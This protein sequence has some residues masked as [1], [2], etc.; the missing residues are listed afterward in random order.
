M[1]EETRRRRR[2][3]RRWDGTRKKWKSGRKE[4]CIGNVA[5]AVAGKMIVSS[6]EDTNTVRSERE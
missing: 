5:I 6:E 1:E 4:G 3:K 2:S